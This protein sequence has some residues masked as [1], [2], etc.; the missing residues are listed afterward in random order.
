MIISVLHY[1]LALDSSPRYII[2]FNFFRISANESFNTSESARIDS[3]S[4]FAK[5]IAASC[6]ERLHEK[7]ILCGQRRL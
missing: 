5:I 4:L 7:A 1:I 3:E 6:I 2:R